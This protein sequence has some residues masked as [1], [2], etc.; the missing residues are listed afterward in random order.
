MNTWK[1]KT[2]SGL[3]IIKIRRAGE[4]IFKGS[5]LGHFLCSQ[6]VVFCS[7]WPFN[8]LHGTHTHTMESNLLY[9]VFKNTY[10]NCIHSKL[11]SIWLK[12][13]KVL[14]HGCYG[15]SQCKLSCCMTLVTIYSGLSVVLTLRQAIEPS[16]G[17]NQGERE[18]KVNN[19]IEKWQQ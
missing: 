17:T 12:H 18:Y 1:F 13:I 2:H 16:S 11:F 3:S 15:S 9:S 5:L 6:R 4:M 7:T 10:N 19:G 14:C 8:W